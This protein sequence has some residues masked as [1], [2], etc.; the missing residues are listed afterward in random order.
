MS[1]RNYNE[2][3]HETNLLV[4]SFPR[5]GFHLLQTIFESY[6]SIYECACQKNVDVCVQTIVTEGKAFHRAHD[7]D[8]TINKKQFNKTI[9]VYRKYIL[10]SLDACFRYK[11]R[12][13]DRD[14]RTDDRKFRHS[15]CDEVAIPYS[16][17]LEFFKT[18]L[19]H[20]KDWVQ[21]WI[22]EPTPNSIIIEYSEFMRNPEITLDKLQEFLLQT[23][24][25]EL[26]AKIV[27]EMKI[28]YRHCMST[29]KREELYHLL[30][31]LN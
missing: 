29:Q 3:K 26:S 20:Y 11:F 16:Q 30:F 25:S 31:T 8:L 15:S 4:V 18:I 6:F 17:K 23:K 5:S 21:K 2:Q 7:M 27:E 1:D 28:E 12:S 10:E 22:N 19:K 9:I 24:N 14:G 13:F